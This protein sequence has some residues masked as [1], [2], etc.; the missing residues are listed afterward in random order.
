MPPMPPPPA[1]GPTLTPLFGPPLSSVHRASK[2][3]APP[4]KPFAA[5]PPPPPPFVPEGGADV[6]ATFAAPPVPK[7]LFP[8]AVVFVFES[9]K[10]AVAP[11][12]PPFAP[13]PPPPAKASGEPPDA[14]APL[15][16][17]APEPPPVRP[18]LLATPF[19]PA[20]VTS[21]TPAAPPLLLKRSVF[22]AAFASTVPVVLNHVL[23]PIPP[24]WQLTGTPDVTETPALL[25]KPPDPPDR[26]LP[27]KVNFQPAPPAPWQKTSTDVTPA[28]GVQLVAPVRRTTVVTATGYLPPV[29]IR[30]GLRFRFSTSRYRP[31]RQR[32]RLGS[33]S[34]SRKAAR[35]CRRAPGASRCRLC[36]R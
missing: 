28:G 6:L 29:R 19:V 26:L 12:P 15:G 25:E 16:P 10:T 17:G 11:A 13:P 1:P 2:L 9:G 27:E 3:P 23:L 32:R 22:P 20:R 33:R 36:P 14:P 31:C 7:R 35:C 18:P 34:W 24:I 21:P 30:S 5:E 4:G 8:P